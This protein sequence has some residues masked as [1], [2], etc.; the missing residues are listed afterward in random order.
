MLFLAPVYVEAVLLNDSMQLLC[1]QGPRCLVTPH[2]FCAVKTFQ[3][4]NHGQLP[5][6]MR[7]TWVHASHDGHFDAVSQT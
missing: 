4:R 2:S 1:L 7:Q 5:P 6:M 3:T